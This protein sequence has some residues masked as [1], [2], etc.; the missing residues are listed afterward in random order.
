MVA[1]GLQTNLKSMLK[2]GF[3]PLIIGFVASATV[4]I[5]SVV[6]LYLIVLLKNLILQ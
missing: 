6:Y 2:L 3:K 4:G 5:V 1:L